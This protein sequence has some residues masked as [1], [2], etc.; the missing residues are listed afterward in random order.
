MHSSRWLQSSGRVCSP[1]PKPNLQRC[2]G[3]IKIGD[4]CHGATTMESILLKDRLEGPKE[5]SSSSS[6]SS[7]IFRSQVY[8]V[9]AGGLHG[10][11]EPACQPLKVLA[12]PGQIPHVKNSRSSDKRT[13]NHEVAGGG[14]A[15]RN[16][17][18]R[19]DRQCLRCISSLNPD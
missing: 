14:A 13:I 5:C 15:G 17:D 6:S 4:S 2:Y 8:K 11:W 12:D 16:Q 3:V 18:P 9:G 7:E 10:H 1:V 19:N